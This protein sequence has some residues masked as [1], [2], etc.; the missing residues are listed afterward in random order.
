MIEVLSLLL[1]VAVVVIITAATGYF[2]AQEFAYMAVDR[3]GLSARAEAG[4]AA[5]ARALQVTRRTS[6]M[7]SGAQ[8][9]ITVTGLLVGYVA[10]PLIGE[11]LSTLLGGVAVPSGVSVAVGAVAALVFSTLVQMLFGEL[12]PKNLAIARPEPVALRLSGSTVLFLRVFGWLIWVFDQASILFLRALRIEPVHDV[13][14]AATARDLEHIVE[15]SRESGDLP[16]ELSMLLDRIL[17]FPNRPVAH[18]MIP[19]P[20]VDT[21]ETTATV[22]ELR[23]LMASGHSRY[24]VLEAEREEVVGVVHLADVLSTAYPDRAPVTDIV[25]PCLFVSTLTPLP[26]ALRE[27]T[28]SKNQLACVV[29]EYGGFAG[30]LTVEDLAEELVGE[31]TDEHDEARPEYVPVEGDGIWEMPGDVHVDEVERA[32]G[33]D[34]PRGR[35]ETVAGLVLA[36]TGSLPAPGDR[37]TIPLPADPADLLLDEEPEPRVLEVEVLDVAR[38]V[39]ARVRLT[40]PERE[41]EPVSA[42]GIGA[43]GIGADGIGADG[44]AVGRMSAAGTNDVEGAR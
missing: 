10:E 8:L 6:F 38:R 26:E 22:G 32:L 28:E 44:T 18:A 40:L 9:G 16:A 5:S 14:H 3:S 35:Y 21:V 31:I 12:L 36:T 20:Q 24:P 19:R 13:E 37:V 23:R 43:D 27:L 33:V 30:V 2:V 7:L 34:L 41:G 17:D 29:D 11:S 25:R 42:D 15:E 39:P 1:G 4:D